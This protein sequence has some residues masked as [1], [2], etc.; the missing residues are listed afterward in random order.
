MGRSLR[1][2]YAKKLNTL[3]SQAQN[4][5]SQIKERQRIRIISMQWIPCALFYSPSSLSKF[6]SQQ[7]EFIAED[8]LFK[9][10]KNWY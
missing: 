3:Y 5:Y 9:I 4:Q 7:M 8:I 2:C 1:K 6:P 10:Y